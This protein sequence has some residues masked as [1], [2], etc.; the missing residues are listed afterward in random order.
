MVRYFMLALLLFPVLLQAQPV[1]VKARFLQDYYI[2]DGSLLKPGTNYLVLTSRKTFNKYFGET[3]RAD[4][5]DFSREILL[6]MA[7]PPQ[8][9]DSKLT[10]NHIS[11]KAG[12]FIEVYGTVADDK[13][14][15]AYLAYPI[16][17]AVLPRY[18]GINQIHFYRQEDMRLMASVEVK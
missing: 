15:H 5:P 16:C 18:P 2:T 14:P 3:K 11:M 8:H 1:Q 6:V 7:L 10:M 4:T 17:M 9:H 13:H 12:N